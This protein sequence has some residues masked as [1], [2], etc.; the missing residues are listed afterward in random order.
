MKESGIGALDYLE[1]RKWKA[2][3]ITIIISKNF[4][5]ACI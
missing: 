1:E 3:D 2:N 5:N 4:N